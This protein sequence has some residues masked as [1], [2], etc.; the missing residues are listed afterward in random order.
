[1]GIIICYDGDFPELS[2][3]IAIKGACI[4]A[5]P[6]ALLRS[7]EIWEM[8]NMARAY[9]NHVYMVSV[10]AVGADAANGYYFGHSMIVSPIARKLALARGAEEIIYSELDP[11]PIKRIT[12]GSDSPMLFDHLQDRNIKSYKKDLLKKANCAFEPS[13]RAPY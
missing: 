5:R 2:R 13:R 12:Y 1:M 4:M 10:N 7:F 8:T 6:S 9:D 11:E 3:V